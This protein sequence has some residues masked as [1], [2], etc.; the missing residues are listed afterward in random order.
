MPTPLST[1]QPE[2]R[3]DYLLEG[4]NDRFPGRV[5][6][7]MTTVPTGDPVELGGPGG[8]WELRAV[9]VEITEHSND[10]PFP[11]GWPTAARPPDARR[12]LR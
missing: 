12:P 7:Q 4:G 5:P 2:D 10:V 3:W 9:R 8:V 6:G 1:G 11:E